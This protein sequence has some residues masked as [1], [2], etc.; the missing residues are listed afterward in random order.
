M[1]TGFHYS[2]LHNK[3]SDVT[4]TYTERHVLTN[5]FGNTYMISFE[6]KVFDNYLIKIFTSS[7][8]QI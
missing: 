3:K 7:E 6:Y 8:K 4:N 5:F 1:L 2:P